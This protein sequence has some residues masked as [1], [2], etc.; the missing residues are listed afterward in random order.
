MKKFLIGLSLLSLPLFASV[1]EPLQWQVSSGYRNDRLHWHLQDPGDGGALTYSEKYRN[2]QFWE[3]GLSLRVYHRDIYFFLGGSYGAFGLGGD[4][5]QK[6]ANLSYATDQ[7]Q[8]SFT[9]D[10]WTANGA[11]RFGYCVNLTEGRTYKTVLIPFV[12]FSAQ[13]ERLNRSGG[14]PDPLIS[15]NAVGADSY[16]MESTLP[17]PLDFTWYGFLVG[18]AFHIDTGARLL[19]DGGYCYNW[20]HL[21]FHTRF[22]NT[23]SMGSPLFTS[24]ST[25]SSIKA[26]AGGNLGQTGWAQM[27]CRIDKSWRAGIGA[28]INYFTSRVFDAKE[29]QQINGGATNKIVQKT[30]IRW[31]TISGWGQIS[32]E[33]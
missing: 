20:L 1:N 18:A 5:S 30:K 9:P 24:Q 28:L 2:L 16:T 6:Y 3:N 26:K 8:F 19:F 27:E 29:H 4:L 23:V 13:Y 12:G 33:F 10:G 14:T 17:G 31:T 22:Q 15:D 7:P 25:Y 32:R 11:G 21:R